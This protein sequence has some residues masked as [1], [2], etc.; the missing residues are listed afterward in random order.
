MKKILTIILLVFSS[1]FIK[2][3]ITGCGGSYMTFTNSNDVALYTA[4]GGIPSS[5]TGYTFELDGIFTVTSNFF[6][7]ECEIIMGP[8][9]RINVGIQNNPAD[10]TTIVN[11]NIPTRCAMQE[12]ERTVNSIY[13]KQYAFETDTIFEH[14]GGYVYDSTERANLENV[15]YQNALEGGNAVYE[16][17][18]MLFIDVEDSELT[19]RRHLTNNSL[20]GNTTRLFSINPNPNNGE[21]QLN[22]KL[23]EGENGYINI[24]SVLGEKINSHKLTNSANA[25]DIDEKQLNEGIYFYR[26]YVNDISVYSGKIVIT[27]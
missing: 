24:Y 22:Y 21:M 12:N 2:A 23:N 14:Q 20:K 26:I 8:G 9:A 17:R 7:T 25:L 15:A 6:I 3:S 27:K 4:L 13:Q 10:T 16:A 18:V 19:T 1:C 11:E 5:V